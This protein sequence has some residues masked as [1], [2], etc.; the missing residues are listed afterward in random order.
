MMWRRLLILPLLLCLLTTA[1]LAAPRSP[2]ADAPLVM[3]AAAGST[4]FFTDHGQVAPGHPG[5]MAL[6]AW[7]GEPEGPHLSPSFVD[8]H[9][10]APGAPPANIS[11]PPPLPDLG[12]SLPL[13]C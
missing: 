5:L 13:R 7:E 11:G 12:I 3:A 8:G 1:D 10:V 9:C 2:A 6:G 4:A